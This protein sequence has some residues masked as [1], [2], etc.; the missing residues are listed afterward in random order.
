MRTHTIKCKNIFLDKISLRSPEWPRMAQNALCRPK[1]PQIQRSSGLYLS[2]GINAFPPC[3][4]ENIFKEKE[5]EIY[6][7]LWLLFNH[8]FIPLSSTHMEVREHLCKSVLSFHHMVPD[9]TWVTRLG[10]SLC[11]SLPTEAVHMPLCIAISFKWRCFYFYLYF[12]CE[13]FVF[14]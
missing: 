4:F 7:T 12:M 11:D 5:I 9:Q 6:F 1:R 14:T 8:L 13:Y 10:G 3:L 2:V